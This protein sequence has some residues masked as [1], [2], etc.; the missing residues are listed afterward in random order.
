MF[1]KE[2]RKKKICLS[3]SFQGMHQS[4]SDN[5]KTLSDFHS[6]FFFEE[7][8][9]Q[10]YMQMSIPK[11]HAREEK[12]LILHAYPEVKKTDVNWC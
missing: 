10:Y 5:K 4:S 8:V 12:S 11:Y 2:G 3:Q 7:T 9:Y 1:F 6:Q